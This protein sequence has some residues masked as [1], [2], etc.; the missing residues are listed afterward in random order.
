MPLSL[1]ASNVMPVQPS[2]GGIW[3]LLRGLSRESG[4][5]GIFPEHLVRELRVEQLEE[6]S[7]PGKAG[8]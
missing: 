4:H 7:P 1:R 6:A 8:L 2:G 3:V 5:W